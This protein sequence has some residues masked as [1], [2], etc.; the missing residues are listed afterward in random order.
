MRLGQV[1]GNATLAIND[2][3]LDA[4]RWLVVSPVAKEDF[5]AACTTGASLSSEASVVVYD[6]LGAGNGD[7]IG[8]VEGAE[9]T[10]PFEDPIPIDAYCAAIFDTISYTPADSATEPSAR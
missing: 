10:A 9:A 7:I 2:P 3:A 1:I 4:G 6:S 8:F 5:N